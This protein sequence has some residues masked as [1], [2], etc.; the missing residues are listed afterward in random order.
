MHHESGILAGGENMNKA[1]KWLLAAGCTVVLCGCGDSAN[2]KE[3]QQTLR[4]QGI[5]QAKTG[6][7]DSAVQSF[8]QALRLS[9]MQVGS[10]E[11]DIAA[12]KAASEYH[13]GNLDQA[14]ET[15]SAILDIKK[16]AEIYLTRGL[17]YRE[18]ENQEAANADFTEALNRTSK[19]DLIMRGRLYYYMKDY[20]NAKTCLEEAVKNGNQE[21]MYWQAE[22]YWDSGNQDYAVSLYQSYLSS[23]APSHQDAYERMAAYQISQGNY[24]EALATLESGIAM[25]DQGSLRT[26]LSGEIAVYEQKSDFA[27]A[28]S[29]ME[30]YLESYPDDTDAARE[31]EFLKSR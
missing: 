20:T 17:L 11:L 15:C 14:I 13:Q 18:A 10:L 7:Y 9:N 26:L 25:G 1:V 12:Y 4:T 29:K 23:E 6:D 3:Q 22:L 2:V 24:D 31:Y 16:S 28:K 27:T 8:D 21:G 19:K 5:E 30:S